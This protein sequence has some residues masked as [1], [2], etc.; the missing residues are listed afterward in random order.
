MQDFIYQAM[1]SVPYCTKGTQ[2]I[3]FLSN[4]AIGT[5]FKKKKKAPRKRSVN[6]LEEKS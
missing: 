2:Q 6:K 4:D 5:I 3:N 1:L